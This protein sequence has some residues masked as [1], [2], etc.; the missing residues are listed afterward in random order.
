M[1][2]LLASDTLLVNR[3]G[4]TYT[5]TG[6][7]LQE[8]VS[9]QVL[10]GFDYTGED[11]P[12]FEDDDLFLVNRLDT[13]F[14]ITFKE[15][16]DSI[17]VALAPVIGN[18]SLVEYNPG[19]D[20]RFT[21]QKFDVNVSMAEEGNPISEK[22][23]DAYVQG[24][25]MAEGKFEEPLDSSL[26]LPG[27][28]TPTSAAEANAWQD[29][30]YGDGKFVAVSETGTNRVMYSYDGITWTSA[31]AAKA[32]TW[33]SVTYGNGK[34]VA[35]A[36]NGSNSYVM[37]STDGINWSSANAAENNKWYSVTFGEGRFVAVSY[38]G[39]NRVMY[40]DDGINWTAAASNAGV[41]SWFD[42]TYG[43][44]KF[45]AVASSGTKQM[46]YSEDGVNW[47][48]LS[49]PSSSGWRSVAYGNGKFVAVATNGTYRVMYS[50][51]GKTSRTASADD[52]HLPG[53]SRFN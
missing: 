5:M 28:W 43:D 20:A 50:K 48:L 18:V 16:K 36:Q 22:T 32:N 10:N 53:H 33:S 47:N 49:S 41:T 35:V 30:T 25:I 7:D 17:T 45:V 42:V 24:A 29:V 13:T 3:G 21:D 19:K 2:I 8:S 34:F 26:K 39:T 23:I 44:D 31:S 40:S 27:G 1:A 4:T 52:D 38:D 6:A 51:E 37:Y 11:I 12:V 46:M 9:D 14:K 15:I